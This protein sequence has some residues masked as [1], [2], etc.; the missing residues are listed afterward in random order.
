MHDAMYDED[1][2]LLARVR[3]LARALPH[4]DQKVSHGRPAFFKV[5]VLA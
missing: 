5:K 4:I 2:P 3:A 1:D